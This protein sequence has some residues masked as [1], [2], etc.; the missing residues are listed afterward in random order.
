MKGGSAGTSLFVKMEQSF[1]ESLMRQDSSQ[2]FKAILVF[3]DFFF[4]FFYFCFYCVFLGKFLFI[5]I[6]EPAPNSLFPSLLV[7]PYA[8]SS[9]PFKT[10]YFIHV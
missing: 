9:F 3:F 10:L 8:A 7:E 6:F 4:F 1:S 5:P 2:G